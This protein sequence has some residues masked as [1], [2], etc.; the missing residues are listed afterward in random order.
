MIDRR[1]FLKLSTTAGASALLVAR[2]GLGRS[3][4][5]ATQGPGLS[6]PAM[7]P[8]FSELVPNALD[9]GF[10]YD[11]SMGKIK[12]AV[13]QTVQM[14]GLVGPDG[15]TPVPTTLGSVACPM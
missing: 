4:F 7:Q 9:P 8:K 2:Y 12:V 3:A 1:T 13:D 11:T 15:L 10:I 5:A 6:D 14:T